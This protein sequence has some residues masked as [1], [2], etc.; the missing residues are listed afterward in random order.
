MRRPRYL[1]T[2]TAVVGLMLAACGSPAGGEPD[3]S[4]G[5][6]P[7]AA[8]EASQAGGDGGGGGGG[9]GL[10]ATLSDGAWTGGEAHIDVSG[11]ATASADAPLTST[12]SLT[13]SASTNLIYTNEAG[14]LIGIAI[15]AD[16]FAISITT[17]EVVAG[18]G[19]TTTCS[20]DWHSTADN[21]L[22]GDFDCPNSPSF[23]ATGGTAGTVNI[24]GSFTATR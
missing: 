14:V 20:V 17:A 6:E 2:A 7:S 19:T 12:L 8:A 18:G 15:Y 4:N 23:T 1:L 13:D 9:G 11:D 24:R 5:A 3:A 10:D 22:S 21:N 16:S